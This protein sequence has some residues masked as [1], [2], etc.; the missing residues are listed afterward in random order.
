MN[1][2]TCKSTIKCSRI[3]TRF[4]RDNLYHVDEDDDGGD[5]D[6]SRSLHDDVVDDTRRKVAFRHELACCV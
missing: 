4:V 3:T 6:R 5:G 1:E 2:Y